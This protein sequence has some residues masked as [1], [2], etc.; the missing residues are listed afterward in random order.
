MLAEH[1][2]DEKLQM[3]AFSPVLWLGSLLVHGFET[4]LKGLGEEWHSNVQP[5][6]CSDFAKL[7]DHVRGICTALAKHDSGSSSTDG[8]DA[9]PVAHV[10]SFIVFFHSAQQDAHVKPSMVKVAFDH[11]NSASC[12]VVLYLLKNSRDGAAINERAAKDLESFADEQVGD[13]RATAATT[14]LRK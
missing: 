1:T 9:I 11:L 3:R 6:L 8:G 4:V 12:S 10:T 7:V 5:I 14:Y 13:A 2:D